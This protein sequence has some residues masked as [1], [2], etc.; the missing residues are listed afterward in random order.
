MIVSKAG[1]NVPGFA[2]R[3]DGGPRTCRG[4]NDILE[5]ARTAA[6]RGRRFAHIMRRKNQPTA[7]SRVSID[8]RLHSIRVLDLLKK[9]SREQA[10]VD[11]TRVVGLS[12]RTAA[13][14]MPGRS[15]LGIRSRSR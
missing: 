9:V 6:P 10:P 3:Q 11:D 8:N 7:R 1:N 15:A 5:E 2:N 14:K 4:A 12:S 13:G